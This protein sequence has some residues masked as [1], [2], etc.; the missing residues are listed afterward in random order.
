MKYS[1]LID[2]STFFFKGFPIKPPRTE[3]FKAFR[4]WI[5]L[6]GG[7]PDLHSEKG[8]YEEGPYKALQ[9]PYKALQGL[10]Q[11]PEVPFYWSPNWHFQGPLWPCS[12]SVALE[13]IETL[14]KP[15][16]AL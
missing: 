6:A 12:L 13:A 1:I 8:V 14:I 5:R 3:T 4:A 7:I 2:K 10:M 11:H 9:G 15:C 16:G